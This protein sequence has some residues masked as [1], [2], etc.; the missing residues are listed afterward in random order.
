MK[1]VPSK[2][3]VQKTIKLFE[4]GNG[5]NGALIRSTVIL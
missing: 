1:I 4:D 3:Q 5:G 2:R